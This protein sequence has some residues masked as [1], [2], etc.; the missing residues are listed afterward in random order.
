MLA[1][2][3][4]ANSFRFGTIGCIPARVVISPGTFCSRECS[5]G[6]DTLSDEVKRVLDL[7]NASQADR[8]K[9]MNSVT[10]FFVADDVPPY[11]LLGQRRE[12]KTKSTKPIPVRRKYKVHTDAIVFM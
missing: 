4:R 12:E 7:K 8:N 1:R 9:V 10:R 3:C 2:G 11:R 6:V 5:F